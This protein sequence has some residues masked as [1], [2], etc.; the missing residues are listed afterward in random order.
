MQAS[1][2]GAVEFLAAIGFAQ[3]EVDGEGYLVLDDA[4]VEDFTATL[5]TRVTPTPLSS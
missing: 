1:V 5:R 4:K 3:Q 2:L